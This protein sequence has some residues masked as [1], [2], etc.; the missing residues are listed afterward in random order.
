LIP[1]YTVIKRAV[2]VNGHT[3]HGFLVPSRLPDFILA[4]HTPFEAVAPS[5]GSFDEDL[6]NKI[7]PHAAV[8]LLS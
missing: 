1:A 7:Q 3:D 6:G 8:D 2:T 4:T 5:K